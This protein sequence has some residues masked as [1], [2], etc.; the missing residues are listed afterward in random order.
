MG[1]CLN[2]RVSGDSGRFLRGLCLV[3]L[4][5]G[6]ADRGCA[7][8]GWCG[9]DGGKWKKQGSENHSSKDD[10]AAGGFEHSISEL[11]GGYRLPF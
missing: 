1:K 3:F 8:L 9:T 2:G 11:S 5:Y 10:A 6:L 4:K 7:P